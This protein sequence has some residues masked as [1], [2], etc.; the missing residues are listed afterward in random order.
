[1]AHGT[2]LVTGYSSGLGAEFT[3]QLLDSGWSVIGVSRKSEPEALQ[4]AYPEALQSVHGSV[5]LQQTVD[6]VAEL[7]SAAPTPLEL[8]INCAGAGAFGAIGQ[9]TAEDIATVINSNL[10]GLILFSDLAVRE[11]RDNGGYIVNVMS[12]AGK[13]LRTAESVYVA[14]KWGAKAYTRTLRDA[15]KADKAPIKVIEVY[16]CGMSTPF[17][18]NAVRPVTDGTS[19]PQPSGIAEQVLQEVHARRDVYCQEFTFERA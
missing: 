1:M 10:A 2:A 4:A 14:S 8:V 17:W 13:K 19:F 3:R 15:M 16:P 5:H 12:T 6:A 9:Y 11:L 7:I 18:A